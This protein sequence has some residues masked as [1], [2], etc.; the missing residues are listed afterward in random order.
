VGGQDV[1]L[2]ACSGRHGE[3][4]IPGAAAVMQSAGLTPCCPR[5]ALLVPHAVVL[6]AAIVFDG[7]GVG[8]LQYQLLYLRCTF[9]AAMVA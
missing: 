1:H 3:Y 6:F 4:P 9:R 8:V 5:I 7:E 2:L